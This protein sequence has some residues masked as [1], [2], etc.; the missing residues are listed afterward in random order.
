MKRILSIAAFICLCFAV[1]SVAM[2]IPG[3]V[4]SWKDMDKETL[5]GILE[6]GELISVDYVG[7]EKIE[8]VSIGILVDAS[9]EKTWKTVTDFE[10]YSRLMPDTFQTTILSRDG[11]TVDVRFEVSVIKAGLLNITTNYVLRY[12]LS[13]PSRAKISWIEGDVKN[14]DGYWELFPV[15][16]GRKTVAIYVITSDLGSVNPIVGRFLA[17]QPATVMAINLS[18]SIVLVKKVVEAAQGHALSIAPPGSEPAWKT[19]D[20]QNLYKL[21][22]GGRVG[23]L[24]R[25][26]DKEIATSGVLVQRSREKV[27][28]VL[29]D[30][31]RYPEKIPQ[32]TRAKVK[33]KTD[34]GAIVKM[35][36]SI[37]QLGP[38]KIS[39]KGDVRYKFEKP[40]KMSSAD[41]K[42]KR[43]DLFNVWELIELGEKD[44]TGLFNSTVSD[45]SAMGSIANVMLSTLPA[46]QES[47]DLS[48]GM[49]MAD[50]LRKWSESE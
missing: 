46:L 11:D 36:T 39:T 24:A 19:M 13:A 29:P 45:I 18:S 2:E 17:V 27:W 40:Y 7:D 8:T 4:P 49:I 32:V 26:G 6:T 15:D 30:F 23:F 47:I 35:K 3:N 12:T 48:Q 31:A 10:G 42:S 44:E 20:K 43:D 34:D 1:A 41:V 25:I 28:G 37:L 50:E 9:P 16:E 38:I 5:S 21:L 22:E 14:V 33:E